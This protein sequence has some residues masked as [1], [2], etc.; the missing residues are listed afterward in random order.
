MAPTFEAAGLSMLDSQRLE[1]CF[2]FSQPT[3]FNELAS[4]KMAA[5]PFVVHE[6][7]KNRVFHHPLRK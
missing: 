1:Q 5:H 3:R 7:V 6:M 2:I 4:S